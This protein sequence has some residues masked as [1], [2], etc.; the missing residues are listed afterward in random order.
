MNVQLSSS[1]IGH[2]ATAGA[3]KAAPVSAVALDTANDT[4]SSGVAR[5]K[6]SAARRSEFA[7][8]QEHLNRQVTHAQRSIDFLD[9][10][11]TSL[12]EL[13]TVLSGSV[14]R[15]SSEKATLEASLVR[16]QTHWLTRHA[17]T[18][19]ALGPDLAFHD[20][21]GAQQ[22]FRIRALDLQALQNERAEILTVYP[23]GAGKPAVSMLV[24]G[25]YRSDSEWARRIDYALAPTG[26]SAAITDDRELSFT[27]REN[28]W[29]EMR[30][31]LMIQGSG[32][33]FPTG[34][35]SRATM[36]AMSPAIDP[37]TWQTSDAAQQRSTL[38]NVVQAVDHIQIVRDGLHRVLTEAGSTIRTDSHALDR[39]EAAQM[40]TAFDT[41]L[42]QTGDFQRF[43]TI[44]AALRGLNSHRVRSVAS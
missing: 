17:A 6:V 35:P 5:R 38:R 19:G 39:D 11:L 44:G 29:P 7:A 16:V 20:D 27:T 25:R 36:E 42:E 34:R 22:N 24:D 2:S 30:E 43:T 3:G 18:G 23:R 31:Q 40:A 1:G 14:A 8:R 28:R 32:C 13:K 21:G 41:A 12:Q 15:R 9:Q 37:L 33:R 4:P 10:T 26:I